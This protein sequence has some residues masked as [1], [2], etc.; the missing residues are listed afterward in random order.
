MPIIQ[1]TPEVT[2]FATPVAES[3]A[4]LGNY[5]WY[6]VIFGLFFAF[7]TFVQVLLSKS[8][9]KKSGWILPGLA[10]GG[11]LMAVL[12]LLLIGSSID[13][14][15]FHSENQRR[16]GRNMAAC[17]FGAS[18]IFAITQIVWD[19]QFVD[20]KFLHFLKSFCKT[21]HKTADISSIVVVGIK[22]VAID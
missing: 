16:V 1:M 12:L 11:A 10:F 14:M 22:L 3:T 17:T 18:S 4:S 6:F 9:N 7:L 19:I 2:A 21:S 8:D 5:W 13:F 20:T 15:Q